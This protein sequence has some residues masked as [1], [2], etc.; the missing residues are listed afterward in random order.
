MIYH[1]VDKPCPA[2]IIKSDDNKERKYS[3]HIR[4]IKKD[5]TTTTSLLKLNSMLECVEFST[6]LIFSLIFYVLKSLIDLNLVLKV[7]LENRNIKFCLEV[8]I[9]LLKKKREKNMKSFL[10]RFK[11]FKVSNLK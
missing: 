2:T 7:Y 1:S 6:F 8:N 10:T 5:L 4:Q 11:F 9:T 3:N